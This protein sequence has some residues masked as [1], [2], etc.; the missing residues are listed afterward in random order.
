MMGIL[1]ARKHF[2]APALAP[3]LLNI[4]II[5]GAFILS[6]N[7]PENPSLGIAW[8]VIVGG[9]LQLL[10]QV[11]F[12]IR[13]GFFPRLSFNFKLPAIK[14]IG[15]LMLPT[16]W[17]SAVYQFNLLAIT[18]MASFL[19]TGSISYLW[20]ADRIVEFP[21]GVFA[22]SL[23]TVALPTLSD[24]AAK[25]D[26]ALMRQ[27]LREI[28]SM[29]WILNIPAAIGLAVLAKPVLALLFYRGDFG[30]ESTVLTAQ[31]LVFFAI[32]LPFVSATRITASAFY[33]I[34]EAKKPVR[35]ANLSVLV[36]VVS[37]AVLMFPLQYRGLALAVSLGSLTNFLL[38]MFFYRQ[39]IGSLGLR[40]LLK[41][42]G[43]I[44]FASLVMGLGL[45]FL[46]QFWNLTY[47][48]FA[49][50]LGFVS[51]MIGV[52]FLIYLA[53]IWALKVEGLELLL[54]G[55]RRRFSRK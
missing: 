2:V 40:A 52:G 31:A 53:L 4:G 15:R 50:R 49:Q 43:K 24:H 18:F 8:G 28:L 30:V 32:G 47:A 41:N 1:N 10:I 26:Y 19:P 9:I 51:G 54:G 48:P 38:I 17:G 11:P 14:K 23:A 44:L 20:Y 34:Q 33:A 37:G 22:I 25:K 35:A 13:H 12:L 36:T 27:T 3:V 29:V 21:L 46:M 5:F 6:R 45:V 7:H 39:K 55:V 42:V 16:L